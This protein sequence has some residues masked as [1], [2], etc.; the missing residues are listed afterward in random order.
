MLGRL[1]DNL[2]LFGIGLSWGGFESLV[3]PVGQPVRSCTR[4]PDE[5]YLIRVHAGLEHI[6]DLVE[7]FH[8]ALDIAFKQCRV[9]VA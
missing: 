3:V 5:G 6:D 2:Q 4:Q 1:F 9:A 7:D 8:R